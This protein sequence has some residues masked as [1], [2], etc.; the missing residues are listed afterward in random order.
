VV[1]FGVPVLDTIPVQ[2]T[3][4][5]LIGIVLQDI[6]VTHLNVDEVSA[7]H[8]HLVVIAEFLLM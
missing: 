1:A 6:I 5:V 3:G 4:I 2:V 7:G 8:L